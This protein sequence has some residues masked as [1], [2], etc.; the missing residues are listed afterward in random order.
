[1][2][3]AALTIPQSSGGRRRSI[4]QE[5]AQSAAHPNS[6]ELDHIHLLL[7]FFFFS[8]DP[9]PTPAFYKAHA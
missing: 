4:S 8:I 2:S 6:N 7:G 1:M 5:L 9:P 3:F